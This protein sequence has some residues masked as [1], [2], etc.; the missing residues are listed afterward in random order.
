M[1]ISSAIGGCCCGSASDYWIYVGSFSSGNIYKVDPIT[2]ATSVF[3]TAI[4]SCRSMAC[5]PIT[6]Y[7]L[8]GSSPTSSSNSVY[9]L[10]SSGSIVWNTAMTSGSG[11]FL[12]QGIAVTMDGHVYVTYDIG[13]LH[14]LDLFTGTEITTGGW[15]YIPG[16][17]A[18]FNGLCVDTSSNIYVSGDNT[19]RTVKLTK[20]DSSAAVQWTSD[21][22]NVLSAAAEIN[23]NGVYSV[24]C[25]AA[26]TSIIASRNTNV[27]AEPTLNAHY[28][29]S[30]T[31]GLKTSQFRGTGNETGLSTSSIPASTYGPA[32]DHFV[33]NLAD[34][35]GFT[36]HKNFSQLNKLYTATYGI[37][38]GRDGNVFFGA[39][40]VVAPAGRVLYNHTL[41][42]ETSVLTGL[43]SITGLATSDGHIGAFG[44]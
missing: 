18:T 38:V 12:I 37:I 29:L 9:C 43:S 11:N 23:S 32:G 22:R 42:W 17:G 30:A 10:D 5:E 39:N 16:G 4:G 20:I 3:T 40:R 8:I 35:S 21:V 31:T 25:N 24:G 2:G 36:V 27:A 44:L 14:K 26:G 34:A 28:V 1:T 7:V 41:G 19:L 6:G 33:T 13:E 15:P